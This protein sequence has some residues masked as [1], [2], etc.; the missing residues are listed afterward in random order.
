MLTYLNVCITYPLGASN[1]CLTYK[2]NVHKRLRFFMQYKILGCIRRMT[3]SVI[4]LPA[5]PASFAHKFLFQRVPASPGMQYYGRL[6]IKNSVLDSLV[7]SGDSLIFDV[8]SPRTHK[9]KI[10]NESLQHIPM[11]SC[12]FQ[13]HV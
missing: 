13:T 7:C 4:L 1:L 6:V 9:P 12:V 3:T 2:Q 5:H 11:Y 8:A 10:V